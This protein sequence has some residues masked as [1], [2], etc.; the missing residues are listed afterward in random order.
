MLYSFN[1]NYINVTEITTIRKHDMDSTKYPYGLTVYF[2][3]EPKE[4][5]VMY[6]NKQVR[7]QEAVAIYDAVEFHYRRYLPTPVTQSDMKYALKTETDKIR[8]EIKSL[9][10]SVSEAVTMLPIRTNPVPTAP[11]NSEGGKR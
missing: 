2:R 5:G 8:R 10:L 11:S 1:G 9:R 4:L 7:D 6:L 3:S